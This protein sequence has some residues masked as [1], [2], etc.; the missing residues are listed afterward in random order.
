M[1]PVRQ[2]VLQY[3]YSTKGSNIHR[4]IFIIVIHNTSEKSLFHSSLLC[5]GGMTPVRQSYSNIAAVQR[6]TNLTHI[7]TAIIR[8][9]VSNTL[10]RSLECHLTIIASVV[11][12]GSNNRNVTI[13]A[14]PP[15]IVWCLPTR[16][17]RNLDAKWDLVEDID[18]ALTVKTTMFQLYGTET[19]AQPIPRFGS[20]LVHSRSQVIIV[21]EMDTRNKIHL[22]SAFG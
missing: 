21:I 8:E 11:T 5:I 17:R 4:E 16:L 2:A 15:T 22:R 18:I 10:I 1:T 13:R 20:Q 3:R 9:A 12:E 19:S 14:C 6:H 7:R